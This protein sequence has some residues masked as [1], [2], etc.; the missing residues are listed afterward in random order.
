MAGSGVDSSAFKPC[1]PHMHPSHPA[2]EKNRIRGTFA[3]EM[4][5]A[6][7]GH[8]LRPPVLGLGC[9]P[10]GPPPG[11]QLPDAQARPLLC[12]CVA[13]RRSELHLA[14]ARIHRL[15]LHVHQTCGPPQPQALIRQ[16][17]VGV[18]P[19][20]GGLVRRQSVSGEG[21]RVDVPRRN[22]LRAHPRRDLQPVRAGDPVGYA[23]AGDRADAP[24]RAE[25][26]G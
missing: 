5:S 17:S 3:L 18:L 21:A 20:L 25:L 24:R 9:P 8:L 13:S 15:D 12:I 26:R 14:C 4:D 10:V 23:C 7:A 1:G 6:Y 2:N 11:T 19:H 16:Q 22:I